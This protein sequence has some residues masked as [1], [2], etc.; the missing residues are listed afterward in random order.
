MTVLVFWYW[1]ALA[2]LLLVLELLVSGFFFL[3]LAAAAGFTGALAWLLPM[4]STNGQLF[5]FAASSVL[6]IVLWRVYGKTAPTITD[7]PLLNKRGQQYVGRV[8]SL[9]TAIINGQ[10][11]IKVDDSLWTV[12]GDDCAQGERVKVVAVQGTVFKVEKE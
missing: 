10:G 2:M 1:W 3:W 5:L 6:A 7:H 4:L 12:H 11:K 8:F 9:H